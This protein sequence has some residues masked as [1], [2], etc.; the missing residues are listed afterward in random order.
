[1]T[2]TAR[3]K[4]S[5]DTRRWF[6]EFVNPSLIPI[7]Y[8]SVGGFAPPKP[9]FSAS[10][11]YSRPTILST[12]RLLESRGSP[13]VSSRWQG[14]K[15]DENDEGQDAD[16]EDA[17]FGSGG[18]TAE[19]GLA[20]RM[21]GEEAVLNHEPTVGDAVEKG[22]APVPRGVEADGPPERAGAPEAETEDHAGEKDGEQPDGGFARIPG[23]AEEEE[24][25]EDDGGSPETPGGAVTGFES[26]LIE[27]SQAAGER[28]LEVAAGEVLLEHANQEEAGQ[29]DGSVLENVAAKQQPGV[30]DEEPR[31]PERQDQ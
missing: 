30:K 22:L 18:S 9:D 4:A 21:G 1:M 27:A 8:R 7:I 19:D 15:N 3:L 25:G 17:A 24:D 28:V 11:G 10:R 20:H 26:P 2:L 29:P 14:E 16:D 13:S 5:P 6:S 23:M 31:F 12:R